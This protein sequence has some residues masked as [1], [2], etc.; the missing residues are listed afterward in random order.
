MVTETNGTALAVRDEASIIE[1]VI[2]KGDLAQLDPSERVSYYRAVCRSLGLNELTQPF[3]YIPLNGRLTLY[4]GKGCTDQLRELKGV[5]ITKIEREQIGDL[6]VVTAY[7]Q[8]GNRTDSEI[9]AVTVAG[10]RGEAL[11]NAMMKAITKAKRR[12]TLSI[13]GLGMLDE[14]EIESIAGTQTVVVDNATGEIQEQPPYVPTDVREVD[15]RPRPP[16]P[17]HSQPREQAQRSPRPPSNMLTSAD[18]QMWQRWLGLKSDAEGLGLVVPELR[19]PIGRQLLQTEGLKVREA[20]NAR[21]KQLAE[22]DA[23]RSQPM[24]TSKSHPLWKE[25]LEAEGKARSV[26]LQLDTSMVA[27]PVTEEALREALKTLL[28]AVADKAKAEGLEDIPF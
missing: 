26:G 20:V 13:C 22:E 4:A 7:A 5:N 12:V 14:S 15:D 10:L 25:W 18:E 1:Q 11:A 3:Q 28:E 6:F 2:A 19:L 24:V 17:A 8:R 23:A 21:R 27:L 16:Q 9:G